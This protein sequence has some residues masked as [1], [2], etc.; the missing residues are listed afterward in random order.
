MDPDREFD[1]PLHAFTEKEIEDFSLDMP[2]FGENHFI[3]VQLSAEY[4]PGKNSDN[5]VF[6]SYSPFSHWEQD[7][8]LRVIREKA[9]TD[10]DLQA[11]LDQLREEALE[12]HHRLTG[13]EMVDED[14]ITNG[15]NKQLDENKCKLPA[16]IYEEVWMIEY[17]KLNSVFQRS[18]GIKDRSIIFNYGICIENSLKAIASEIDPLPIT[19]KSQSGKLG[20]EWYEVQTASQE[21]SANWLHLPDEL[22][23][24]I[25]RQLRNLPDTYEK[26]SVM[27]GRD[28]LVKLMLFIVSQS[29][30]KQSRG[31]KNLAD[32]ISNQTGF[33]YELD[34]AFDWRNK[35]VHRK[36]E[37]NALSEDKYEE[38]LE[39]VEKSMYG[40][41]QLIY[42][43]V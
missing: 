33:L 10:T 3:I 35:G 8:Y 6:H 20:W 5:V 28:T 40:Y 21:N 14:L 39:E 38:G 32:A 17:H 26:M 11:V 25:T 43:T 13:L 12:K 31:I 7:L 16:E 19:F 30:Q 36:H 42:K 24:K 2:E 1:E 27:G 22:I 23:K 37:V 29:D 41:L 15:I 18:K 4:V 9:D 34:K